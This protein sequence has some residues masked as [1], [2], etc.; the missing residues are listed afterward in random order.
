[1]TKARVEA[2]LHETIGQHSSIINEASEHILTSG[3]KR[4]RPVFVL[5]SGAFGTNK[6]DD[7]IK[8]ATALEIIHMA[9]LVH[10]DYID[11]SDKRRGVS[12]IHEAYNPVIA[13]RTGHYL[14]AS[15]LQLVS[16]INNKAFHEYLSHV[17]L[18][19]CYGEFAQMEDTFKTDISFTTYLRRIN[20]KTA[21]LLEASCK[22]GAMST[23]AD[24]NDIFNLAKFGHYMGMCYQIIDD[25]LDYTSDE[26]TL[27]KPVGGDIIN[28]HMT[29]PLMCAIKQQPYIKSLIDSVHKK[30]DHEQLIEMVNRFG[31]EDALK[32]SKMY[33]QKAHS[34]L[35]ALPANE[36]REKMRSLLN[37]MT[38]RTF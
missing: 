33:A 22:L 10:D 3:G 1:M 27:G 16:T 4:I 32:V 30:E 25:V 35:D 5:L 17:I 24:S 26:E 29:L 15:A 9:S 7:L 12:A 19:V 36:A 37:K 28:G 38:V 23:D 14:L 18:E 20:R 31:V 6:S 2:L 11:N 34:A 13:V 21:I 8:T